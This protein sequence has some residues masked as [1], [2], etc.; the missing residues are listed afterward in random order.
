MIDLSLNLIGIFKKFF[1]GTR[2]VSSK[3]QIP[4]KS[5]IPTTKD[6][7][8]FG[9]PEVDWSLWFVCYLLFVIWNFKPNRSKISFFDQTDRLQA[10]TALNLN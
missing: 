5:Q 3:H 10:E 2:N 6:P 7:N 4:M 9:P 8:R 1:Q